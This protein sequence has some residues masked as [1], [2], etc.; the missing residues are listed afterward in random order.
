MPRLIERNPATGAATYSNKATGNWLDTWR[1]WSSDVRKASSASR[2][3][4]VKRC[5]Q[6]HDHQP[7][8]NANASVMAIRTIAESVSGCA[9]ALVSS[10]A[11]W[12]SEMMAGLRKWGGQ[13]IID[14]KDIAADVGE[15]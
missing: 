4:V 12:A 6:R 1:N 9:D 15:A 8:T 11:A 5:R 7:K 3:R 2:R 13:S 10:S 14:S